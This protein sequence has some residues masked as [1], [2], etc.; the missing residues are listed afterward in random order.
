MVGRKKVGSGK[1]S[2]KLE[3]PGHCLLTEEGWGDA[4]GKALPVAVAWGPAHTCGYGSSRVTY[5]HWKP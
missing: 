4:A 5:D 2:G 1:V 3:G